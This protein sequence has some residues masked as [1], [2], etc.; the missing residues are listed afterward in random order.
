MDRRNFLKGSLAG[1]AGLGVGITKLTS[2]PKKARANTLSNETLLNNLV[3]DQE[4]EINGPSVNKQIFLAE[5]VLQNY[6][7]TSIQ[8]AFGVQKD[9]SAEAEI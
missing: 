6:A 3:E 9:A 2:T 5:P 4:T 7:A 8:I 1:V